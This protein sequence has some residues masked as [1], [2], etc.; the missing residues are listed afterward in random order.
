M[1][2]KLQEWMIASIG[3]SIHAVRMNLIILQPL[4]VDAENCAVLSDERA[5]HIRKVLKA[6]VGKEL[7]IGLL[8]GPLG[9]GTVQTLENQTVE[10]SCIFK[11]EMPPKPRIDLL[12]AMPRPKV[13][14][15]MWAQLAALGVGRIVLLR[16]EKVERYYFDSHVVEPGFYN[17]LLIEGLQQACCTR[18]PDVQ[19]EPLFKPFVEDR[20]ECEFSNHWKLLADPSGEKRLRN[21]QPL[22]SFA[23]APADLR[24]KSRRILLAIGP[25]GGWTSYEREMLKDRGFELIGMGDRIL[26]TDTATMG[27]LSVLNELFGSDR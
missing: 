4:E 12:L 25:E 6:E 9:I 22:S 10:L 11:E 17:K 19:V 24:E 27:L 15:R 14:K 2:T 8:N 26:R 16:A 7:K 13:L 20:L 21:F 1:K 3:R 5:Q 18:L 23:K